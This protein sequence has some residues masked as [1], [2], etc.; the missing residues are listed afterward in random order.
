[1]IVG[2]S[3]CEVGMI[4]VGMTSH[5]PTGLTLICHHVQIKEMYRTGMEK[6]EADSKR[7]TTIIADYKQIC[8]QLSERLEKQQTAA[9]EDMCRLRVR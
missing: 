5:L 2:A 7:N 8:S 6:S 9:R 3:T 1:M 4:Y